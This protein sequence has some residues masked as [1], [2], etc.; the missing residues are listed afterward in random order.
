MKFKQLYIDLRR[1][2]KKME[3]Y[4]VSYFSAQSAFFMILSIFPFLILMISLSG[5]LP[6]GITALIEK[7]PEEILPL[8]IKDFVKTL[9]DEARSLSSSTWII[10]GSAVAAIWSSSKGTL[11]IIRGLDKFSG[12]EDERGFFRERLKACI[13]TLLIAVIIVLV[14]FFMVVWEW[15]LNLLL[16]F[17][18][19]NYSAVSTAINYRVTISFIVLTFLFVFVYSYMPGRKTKFKQNI[20]GAALAS[21]GWILVSGGF[22]IYVS[23]FSLTVYGSL[24]TIVLFM[25]WL[26][27][28]LW[29]LFLG[30]AINRYRKN[31]R[32]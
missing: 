28:C 26:Y 10:I 25:V 4:K 27:V 17:L 21:L 3:L 15:L 22:S 31:K 24:T 7:T 14:F 6:E 1:E 9:I 29:L 8:T 30:A 12:F 19:L 23:H 5:F 18:D 11:A 2:I 13:F 20:L 32:Q 16:S